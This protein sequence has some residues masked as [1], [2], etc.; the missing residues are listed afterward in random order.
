MKTA[1]KGVYQARYHCGQL[2]TVVVGNFWNSTEHAS[3]LPHLREE[4]T[5]YI[6]TNSLQSLVESCS[7]EMGVHFQNFLSVLNKGQV[8]SSGPIICSGEELQVLAVESLRI[9]APKKVNAEGML[10]GMG[11]TQECL[12]TW[13]KNPL[14]LTSCELKNATPGYR[15]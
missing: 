12:L 6:F 2:G 13:I 9:S 7:G 3:E 11:E 8:G 5:G 14:V 15:L 4:G 1:I 10:M